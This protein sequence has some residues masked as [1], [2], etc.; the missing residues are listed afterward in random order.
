MDDIKEQSIPAIFEKFKFNIKKTSRHGKLI[1]RSMHLG[2]HS[3]HFL[4]R[5]LLSPALQGSLKHLDLTN[6]AL[7][8]PG[9][10]ALSASL[11]GPCPLI[12]LNLSSNNLTPLGA[13]PLF[14][15]LLTNSTLIQL[16]LSSDVES[17]SCNKLGPSGARSL[18]KLL[19]TQRYLAIV[20][21][22]GNAIGNEG[23]Q[24]LCLALGPNGGHIESLN[25]ERNMVGPKGAKDMVEAIRRGEC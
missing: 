11:A 6:N 22:K 20:N 18:A 12:S 21:V 3:A 16:N 15:A 5:L 10:K 9:I 25:V 7:G 17:N 23:M 19:E 1:L 4:S 2:S 24:A 14:K 8:D 13:A